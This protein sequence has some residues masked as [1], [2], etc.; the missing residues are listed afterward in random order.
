MSIFFSDKKRK[1]RYTRFDKR[2]FEFILSKIPGHYK[3]ANLKGTW[4]YVY[5][6]PI[7]KV[8]GLGIRIY[9]SVDKITGMNRDKGSDAIRVMLLRLDNQM[10][11]SE[12]EKVLRTTG[13]GDRVS[14]KVKELIGYALKFICPHCQIIMMKRSGKHG[15]FLGCPN[16]PDCTHTHSL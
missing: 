7:L 8:P 4:E 15:V 9:S 16:Y 10:M 5:D 13:W 2:E 11:L 6:I 1:S 12:P 14:E 3:E